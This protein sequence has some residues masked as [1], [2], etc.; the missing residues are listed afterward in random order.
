MGLHRI[1]VDLRTGD[2]VGKVWSNVEGNDSW[3]GQ[4]ALFAGTGAAHIGNIALSLALYAAEANRNT[5]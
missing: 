4:D 2:L 5:D 3:S 1:G